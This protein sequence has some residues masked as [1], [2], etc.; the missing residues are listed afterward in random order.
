MRVHVVH[1]TFMALDPGPSWRLR[2]FSW[3]CHGPA[4][5]FRGA[6][7]VLYGAFMKLS[8]NYTVFS[9]CFYG[10]FMGCRSAFMRRSFI[11]IHGLGELTWAFYLRS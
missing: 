1:G 9:W 2:G 8:P 5:C 11:D 6:S 10:D 3:D 7:V 4:W